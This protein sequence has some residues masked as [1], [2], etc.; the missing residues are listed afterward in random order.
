[1]GYFWSKHTCVPVLNEKRLSK[2]DCLL[3]KDKIQDTWRLGNF[4][5]QGPSV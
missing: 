4:E 3:T 2:T 5:I 1:M